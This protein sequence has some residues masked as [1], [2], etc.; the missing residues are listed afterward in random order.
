VIDFRAP[1]WD[2][3]DISA[4]RVMALRILLTLL[5]ALLSIASRFV[6]GMR[7]A[8]TR[9]LTIAIETGEGIAHHF[10][11][12]DRVITSASG[13]GTAPDCV[14]RFATSSQA[15]AALTSR[16]ASHLIYQGL[17]EGTITIEGNP[18]HAMWFSDLTQWVVPLAA[19]PSWSTPPGAYTEP[20][21]TAPWAA[22]ITREPVATELDPGWAGAA[23]QR[24]KL[25]MSRVAAGEPTLEF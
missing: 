20:S 19:R 16:H 10:A 1:P 18:F 7:A 9:D 6:S 3:S 21:T 24:A 8:I 13:R 23:E 14:L 11:F 12:R 15:L 4:G 5:G 22:R 25:R 2:L 17:L